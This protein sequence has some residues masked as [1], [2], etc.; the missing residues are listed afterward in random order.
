MLTTFFAGSLAGYMATYDDLNTYTRSILHPNGTEAVDF[1][2]AYACV[3]QGE[4]WSAHK[5][6]SPNSLLCS[7]LFA[8]LQTFALKDIF[9]YTTKSQKEILA[10]P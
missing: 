1:L 4:Q 9:S 2:Q 6:S 8:E 3:P 10:N 5:H 7:S